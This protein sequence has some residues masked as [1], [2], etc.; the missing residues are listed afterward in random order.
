[1]G[2]GKRVQRARVERGLTQRELGR[3]AGVNRD[4]IGS[5]EREVHFPKPLVQYAIAAVFDL[6]P[7]DLFAVD[8]E[9]AS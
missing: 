9:A 1:M 3:L 8:E 5:V 2:Y 6:D 4:T 7:D